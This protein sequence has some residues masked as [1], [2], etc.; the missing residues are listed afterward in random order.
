VRKWCGIVLTGILPASFRLA[1]RRKKRYVGGSSKRTN[2]ST[3]ASPGGIV[4]AFDERQNSLG[5]FESHRRRGGGVKVAKAKLP[6][7]RCEQAV[8][9]GDGSFEIRGR[10]KQGKLRD[11]ELSATGEVLEVK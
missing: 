11:V 6:E 5:C 2:W 8:M 4:H 1:S 3:M 9:R 10:D 7:V